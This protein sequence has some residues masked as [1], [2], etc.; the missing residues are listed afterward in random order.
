MYM[1]I[2]FIIFVLF[3]FIFEFL[4]L[5]KIKNEIEIKKRVSFLKSGQRLR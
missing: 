3:V 5:K 4:N 2:R 1:T